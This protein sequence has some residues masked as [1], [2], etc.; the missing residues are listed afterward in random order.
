MTKS[1]KLKL[2]W[3]QEA[4][5][6]MWEAWTFVASRGE[7]TADKM[8]SDLEKRIK[9]LEALPFLGPPVPE[10]LQDEREYRQVILKKWPYRVIYRV[11][12]DEK[13]IYIL[14]I[15]PMRIPLETW[16]EEE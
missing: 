2:E 3:T 14:R 10:L 12:E 6:S 16:L 7:D 9:K 13:E 5:D 11:S 4:L 1:K 15:H 8:I